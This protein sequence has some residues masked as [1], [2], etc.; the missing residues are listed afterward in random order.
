M[1]FRLQLFAKAAPV[2]WALRSLL[3]GVVFTGLLCAQSPVESDASP[4]PTTTSP[5]PAAT[6]T[7]VVPPSPLPAGQ[8]PPMPSSSTSPVTPTDQPSSESFR[9]DWGNVP[10]WVGSVLS[11]FSVLLAM[12]IIWR[13]RRQRLRS[14]AEKLVVWEERSK[15]ENLIIHLRN[16]SEVPVFR[17]LLVE[18]KCREQTVSRFRSAHEPDELE[19]RGAVSKKVLTSGSKRLRVRFTGPDGKVWERDARS[20]KLR[21]R[22]N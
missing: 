18:G 6:E 9:P 20:G 8:A 3:G 16:T 13:D 15:S 1:T 12:T 21:K 11:G 7:M 10:A 17:L 2:R 19:P 4:V 22:R 14:Q 5:S